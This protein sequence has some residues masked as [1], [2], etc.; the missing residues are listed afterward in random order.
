[1]RSNERKPTWRRWIVSA[2]FAVCLPA[3][4]GA[5]HHSISGVYDGSR[6]V[7]VEGVVVRFEFVNPHPFVWVEVGDEN[8]NPGQWRLEMDN[9][10]EL[11]RIG[12]TAESLRPGDRVSATGSPARSEP[13][14]LYIR[15]LDHPAGGF[16]YEQV[17][18]R[19]RIRAIR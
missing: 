19:P 9:R 2:A 8:G 18:S 5:V 14:R 15:R 3:P 7:R 6:I 13:A 16:Y 10:S 12:M 4:A 11:V 1:M 17:G